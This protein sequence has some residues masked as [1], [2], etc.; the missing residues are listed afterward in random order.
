MEATFSSPCRANR[1]HLLFRAASLLSTGLR[2]DL[3][4]ASPSFPSIAGVVVDFSK[5][6]SSALLCRLQRDP[7][8]AWG[9]VFQVDGESVSCADLDADLEK[10]HSEAMQM[11]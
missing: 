2:P 8:V 9:E 6:S 7:W 4:F 5:P 11:N 10:Y 3:G 1:S